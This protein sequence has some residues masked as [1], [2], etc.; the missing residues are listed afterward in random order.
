MLPK[1]NIAADGDSWILIWSDAMIEVFLELLEEV[2]NNGKRSDT[3]FKP[4]AWV[5]FRAGVQ[6]VYL[7]TEHITVGKVRSKLDYVC[8]LGWCFAMSS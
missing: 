5:G 8:F 4:K 1:N 3:G 2:H 6:A 7:G